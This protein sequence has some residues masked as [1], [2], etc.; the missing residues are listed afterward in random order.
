MNSAEKGGS[1]RIRTVTNSPFAQASSCRTCGAGW[2]PPPFFTS[3]CARSGYCVDEW[4][5]QIITF[6]TSIQPTPALAATCSQIYLFPKTGHFLNWLRALIPIFLNFHVF[7]LLSTPELWL[8]SG[9]VGWDRRS[10][11]RE[12][13]AHTSCRSTRSCSLGSQPPKP[14]IAEFYF[15]N[16]EVALQSRNLFLQPHTH[17]RVLPN[18]GTEANQ[19]STLRPLREHK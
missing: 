11:P 5:P 13:T 4:L 14:K 1:A 9:R 15:R 10:S 16:F 12:L 3:A 2:E 18:P 19:T 7:F 17:S 6:L 8:G